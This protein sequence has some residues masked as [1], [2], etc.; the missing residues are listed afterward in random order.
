MRYAT[1]AATLLLGAALVMARPATAADM[2]V[3]AAPD[4]VAEADTA[5]VEAHLERT[6]SLLLLRVVFDV[7][8]IDEVPDLLAQERRRVEQ[9]GVSDAIVARLDAD[10]LAEASYFIVSLKYLA[11]AG[12]AIWPEDRAANAYADDA[13]IEL[14]ALQRDLT[15]VVADRTDP[16]PVL[17]RIDRIYWWTEGYAEVPEGG[18]FGDRDL[19][20]EQAMR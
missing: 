9:G 14:D 4:D 13:L 1:I 15:G 17:Q 2:G 18:H 12:G 8:A 3:P 6:A 20:V 16:L 5:T 19:L 10:L 7:N 11:L